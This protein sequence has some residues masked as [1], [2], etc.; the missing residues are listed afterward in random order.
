[1]DVRVVATDHNQVSVFTDSGIQLVGAQ[2]AQ[3]TFDAKGALTADSQWSA[4]P[5]KR[6]VGTISLV[7]PNGGSI[8][9]IAN[10]SIRSG[11]IA[12]YL[13]MRDQILPQA[14]AQL[15][16][17][18]AAMSSA[19]SDHTTAGTV[20]TSGAQSGF[21][22]DIGNLSAGNSVKV[23][24]TDNATGAQRTITIVRV[25]DP[26]ALPLPASAASGANDK[27]IGVDFSGG[28]ASVAAQ[29]NSALG[30]TGL[31]FSNPTGTTLRVLDDGAANRTDVNSL[32]ATSTVTTL[33]GG[34]VEL[35]LFLDAGNPYTGA[36]TSTGAQSVG[37]AG[38]IRV[39][40]ALVA[41]PSRLVVYN[42]SPLTDSG[43]ATRPEFP[44]QPAHRQLAEL[45]AGDR[46][47]HRR[48]SVQRHAV[49]LSAPGHQPA[50]RC[51][52][53]RRQPQ[54]GAGYRRQFLAAAAQRQLRREHRHR[55][56]QPAEPADRLQRERA[57]DDDGARHV[58]HVVA[59]VRRS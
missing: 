16:G 4:D 35:P 50:G 3:L 1:M 2:A 22:V 29:L 8:D 43:D 10:K 51:G 53:H 54:A 30:G 38:R 58:E 49:R 39:N 11:Q 9:L 57:G 5:T 34:S 59:D 23:S 46:G 52:E 27:V 36:I 6:S 28:T 33:T 41:D 15:D 12:A 37:L 42:T 7:S 40:G 20:A 25:D 45:F 31:T 13:E 19:L 17:M 56:G 18:A 32:V 55:D 47:W 44:L 21:K 14:Q 26:K 24:Y 48:R